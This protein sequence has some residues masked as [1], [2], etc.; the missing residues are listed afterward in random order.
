MIDD[1]TYT[2]GLNG[3]NSFVVFNNARDKRDIWKCLLVRTLSVLKKK[4]PNPTP[5]PVFSNSCYPM[6]FEVF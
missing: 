4:H 1:S 3:L 2:V 6:E 5:I